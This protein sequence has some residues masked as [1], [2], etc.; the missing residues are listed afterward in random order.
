MRSPTPAAGARAAQRGYRSFTEHRAMTGAMTWAWLVQGS[1]ALGDTIYT[2][3]IQAAP[4]MFERVAGV[5]SGLL[6]IAFLVFVVAA[7]PAMWN[8]RKSYRRVNHLLERIYG[9]INPI[10]RHA[11]NIADNVDYVT[12]AIRTDIQQLNATITTANQRLQEAMAAT[13][14]RLRDMSALLSVVQEE[15]EQ[16]FVSTASTVRGVQHGASA[17]SRNGGGPKFARQ[18]DDDL[19]SPELDDEADIDEEMID[20]DE[21]NAPTAEDDAARPRVRPRAGRGR[22]RPRTAG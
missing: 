20:G 19:G 1:V 9:D 12:T 13:E 5:A 16:M 10:M 17:L 4:S 14:H 8:F 21:R 11:S 2:K 18:D 22:G 6:T 15:A 3:Q 7:V